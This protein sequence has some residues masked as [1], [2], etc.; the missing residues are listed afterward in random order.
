[1]FKIRLLSILL[2]LSVYFEGLS[3][4]P[5]V[6]PGFVSPVDLEINL[7]GTF[8]EL[9]T[10][11]FHSGIDI[12]TNGSVGH[13]IRSIADGFISRIKVT[14][15]GF[16]KTLYVSHPGGYMS[17]YAHLDSFSRD[18]EEYVR[19]EQYRQESYSVNLFPGKEKF[20]VKQGQVIARSG[21]SGYSLGPHLHFEIRDD[22]TQEPLNPQLF[23][24]RNDDR[25]RPR[26][27]SVRLYLVDGGSVPGY[28]RPMEFKVAKKGIYQF[29][30]NIDTVVVARDFYTG[31]EVYDQATGNASRNGIYNLSVYIDTI[32]FYDHVMDRFNFRETRY[33]N[34]V[35]DY[36]E[37]VSGKRRFIRTKVDPNNKLRI[38]RKLMNDGIIRLQDSVPQKISIVAK[39]I[40]GNETSVSFFVVK[41]GNIDS[42]LFIPPEEYAGRLSWRDENILEFDGMRLEVPAYALYEHV[43]FVYRAEKQTD[44]LFSDIHHI[45]RKETPMHKYSKL[46]IKVNGLSDSLYDKAGL[47]RFDEDWN[48]EYAGGEFQEGFVTAGIR[49]FGIYAVMVDTIPPE[50]KV[51]GNSRSIMNRGEIRCIVTDD[52]SGISSYEARLNGNWILMEYDLKNDMLIYRK[53]DRMMPGIN[54]FM[55]K[56]EDNTGNTSI[57]NA[58]LK[59]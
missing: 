55:L 11:H 56:V 52:L 39:D 51:M 54:E 47:Y 1:M 49:D 21:N 23:G 6:D 44:G 4:T 28:F 26:I 16:G 37:Y 19:N 18:V 2:L 45:H 10:D 17:V 7:S 53:D 3:Q 24:F 59:N 34:S 40:A 12:R 35:I 20:R 30:E 13:A 14:P 50:I 41:K 22:A 32:L 36:A 15:G 8:G 42:S 5:A 27:L 25:V 33:I 57:F 31:I 46:S 48:P 9:R 38:Y 58:L 43:D 29:L